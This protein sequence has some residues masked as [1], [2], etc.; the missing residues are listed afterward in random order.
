MYQAGSWT[1]PRKMVARLE[2]SLQ[3]DG[4]EGTT[5]GIRQE[6]DIRYVVTSLNG[7]A[8][9]LYEDVVEASRSAWNKLVAEQGRIV[10]IGTRCRTAIS[11]VRE[12]WYKTHS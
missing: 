5:T 12:G 11:Q 2:C 10:S 7:A 4:G 3:P 9:Y 8:K 1:R 6:V